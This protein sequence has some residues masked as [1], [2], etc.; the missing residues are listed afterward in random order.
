MKV[1]LLTLLFT[2]LLTTGCITAQ[3]DRR[4]ALQRWARA[5]HADATEYP[6][7]AV[8]MVQLGKNDRLAV[9]LK[10]ED[11][12]HGTLDFGDGLVVNVLNPENEN[13]WATVALEDADR[14]GVSDV[15][16]ATTL[17]PERQPVTAFFLRRPGSW[18][19]FL[20][21]IDFTVD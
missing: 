15:R 8:R 6:V 10:L 16:F 21:P 14:D 19:K 1:V 9:R 20:L 2:A 18:E 4:Y 17:L 12:T 13:L 5:V 7:V 3:T 11:A